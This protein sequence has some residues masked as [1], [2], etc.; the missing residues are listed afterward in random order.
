MIKNL[1]SIGL[2]TYNRANFLPRI[3]DILFS[4]T[5]SN[6]E[7]IISDNASEDD[8]EKICKEYATKNGRIRYIRQNKNLGQ[9]ENFRFV[10]NQAK[11]EYFMWVY[12]DD[13]WD[14]AYIE[15][16]KSVLDTHADYGVAMSS[17]KRVYDDGE[18][19]DEFRFAGLQDL[20]P[21]DYYEVFHRSLL[22]NGTKVSYFLS[23]GLFRTELIRQVLRRFYPD[24]IRFD[25]AVLGEIAL[26]THF[27]S[28]PE[29][30]FSKTMYR[31][32]LAIRYSG[33]LAVKK[34]YS[35]HQSVRHLR[36]LYFIF[37]RITFS[38]LIPLRRKLYAISVAYPRLLWKIT[39][40]IIQFDF[41]RTYM[42]LKRVIKSV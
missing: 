5:Y 1:V 41:P 38:P 25:H 31:K 33:D 9:L 36:Y 27:F 24:C 6:F 20:T 42:V 11:G 12:D 34:A 21:L 28:I 29:V 22:P 14:P 15:K 30:L 13:W 18:K 16:L 23:Y 8:T 2:P 37:Q 10:L 7:I 39:P 19:L 17:Y 40:L 3:F 4:Q 35:H 26:I 32:A